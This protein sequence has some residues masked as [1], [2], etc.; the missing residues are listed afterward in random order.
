MFEGGVEVGELSAEAGCVEVVG[1]VFGGEVVEGDGEDL[2]DE[3]GGGVRAFGP[4][5]VVDPGEADGEG[6]VWGCG[7]DGK[8]PAF[9]EFLLLLDGDGDCGHGDVPRAGVY[10]LVGRG[11]C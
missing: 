5:V 3:A 6:S 1:E 10:G 2:V 7:V 9:V 8:G 11:V 4:V